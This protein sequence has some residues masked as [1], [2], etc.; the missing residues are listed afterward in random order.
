MPYAGCLS[1]Q[2]GDCQPPAVAVP[3]L[4]V[5]HGLHGE[6]EATHGGGMAPGDLREAEKN[7]AVFFF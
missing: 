7:L 4:G 6:G 5:R 1:W 2:P 3:F